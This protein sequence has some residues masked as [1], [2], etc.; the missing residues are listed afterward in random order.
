[1]ED[2]LLAVPK[3]RR[4]LLFSPITIV[5]QAIPVV[6]SAAATVNSKN[7]LGRRV[8]MHVRDEEGRLYC[9][10]GSPYNAAAV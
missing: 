3:N 5:I 1:M 10:L 8:C 2:G 4:L 6:S 9:L 7:D